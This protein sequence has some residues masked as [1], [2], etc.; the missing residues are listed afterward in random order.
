MPKKQTAPKG[1]LSLIPVKSKK[2]KKKR[3][4]VY[5]VEIRKVKLTSEQLK[6]EIDKKELKEL[7]GSIR[8][9]GVVEPISILKVETK[10]RSGGLNV[11]YR[12][13]SGQKRLLAA[14]FAGLAVIPAKIKRQA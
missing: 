9:Y 12:L 2:S 7:A 8:K 14:K 5:Y 6:R 4:S 3:E 11:Y 1:I 10:K 13:I